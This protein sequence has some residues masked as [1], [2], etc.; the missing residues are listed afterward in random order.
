[1]YFVVYCDKKFLY[2]CTFFRAF[3]HLLL[4]AT[5]IDCIFL[6]I[7]KY[8]K[9]R[10]E[11]IDKPE[12]SFFKW[13]SIIVTSGLGAGAI[14]WAAAEPMY[15][16]MEVPPLHSG[17]EAATNEAIAPAMAQSFTS[18]GFTAWVVY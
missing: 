9:V 5:F 11:N 4:I 3:C 17:I 10:L 16:F 6:S 15:Y 14:F 2:L 18:W 8:V 13:V 1:K 12:M 7:T